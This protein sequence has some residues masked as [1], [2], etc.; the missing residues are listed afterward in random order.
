[1]KRFYREVT[2]APDADGWRVLLDGRGVRTPGGAAQI[3]PTEA[4]AAAMAREWA[5]QGEEIDLKQFRLRDLSD[6]TIDVVTADPASVLRELLPYAE[7]DTLCYRGDAG[8]ALNE[9]QATVWE[10]LLNA[11]EQ[12]WDIHFNRICGIIHQPQPP[13][14]LARL[15]AVLS[16]QSPWSLSALRMLSSLAASLVIA[17]AAIEPE[18]D[19]VALWDAANLEEDWQVELWGQDAEAAEL[20]KTRLAAFELAIRFAA[21]AR[22]SG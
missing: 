21:L 19:A 11:A 18:A 9:R 13:E 17:L 15:Q 6:Y 14:T 4:L 1:M 12:R 16:A 5:D 20:R 2:V 7:T 22:D 3:V 8:E 10:P